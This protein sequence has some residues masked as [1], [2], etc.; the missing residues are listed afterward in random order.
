MEEHDGSDNPTTQ[1]VWGIYL[2]EIIQQQLLVS[3]NGF[4]AGAFYPLQDL[5]Y[6]TTGFADSNRVV[7]EAYDT[8]AY[9]NT[10]IFR[11]GGSPP[12]ADRLRQQR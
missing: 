7:R 5:L 6:R 2:D 4:S 9:G 3:L 12:R 11:N 8:D 10:L 1:Y